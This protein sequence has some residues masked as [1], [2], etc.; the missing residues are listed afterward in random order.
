MYFKL[1]FIAIVNKAFGIDSK[2][3]KKTKEKLAFTDHTSKVTCGADGSKFFIFF[4]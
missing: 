4:G 2:K 1:I 3:K